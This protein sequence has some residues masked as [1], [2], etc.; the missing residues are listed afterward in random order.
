MRGPDA[1][2][3]PEGALE[4]LSELIGRIY[5]C[6]LDPGR[7]DDT[8]ER[9]AAAFAPASWDV[10]GL[11]W[12]RFSP[13]TARWVG[14]AHVDPMVRRIYAA[15]FS[16]RNP[17][18]LAARHYA[19][20]TV[21]DTEESA[22]RSEFLRSPLYTDFLRAF[23]YKRAIL[24]TFDRRPGETLGLMMVG[25]PE[26]DLAGLKRG[27]RLLAPHFQRA[28]RISEA[29]GRARRRADT[30]EAALDRAPGAVVTLSE[31]IE[32]VHANIQARELA[33]AGVI[34]LAE[35]RLRLKQAAARA[36]LAAV[37]KAEGTRSAVFTI[38]G[39]EGAVIPVLAAR[40]TGGKTATLTGDLEGAAI[41]VSFETSRAAP[42]IAGG[43]LAAWFG[44]TP[45]ETRLAEALAQGE[46]LAAY[47]AR[48]NVT[49]GAIRFH[50]KA[51]YRKIGATT[52]AQLVARLRDL[53]AG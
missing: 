12:E 20:G 22:L 43:R 6:I 18:S 25:P 24:V 28:A 36:A 39:R 1:R 45:A 34:D 14:Q 10:A 52:R 13:P 48:R 41:I 27:L 50:L 31:T 7:W 5:D 11:I 35:G 37:A 4:A 53:P 30:A 38:P 32:V 49:A 19:L 42:L 17:L 9:L 47:A 8:L 21:V 44:L 16:A 3:L 46:D 29:L 23:G 51:I 2:G 40:M 15:T 33:D 26:P